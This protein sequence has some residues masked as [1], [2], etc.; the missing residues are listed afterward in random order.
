MAIQSYFYDSVNNDRPYSA[1]DFARAFGMILTNGVIADNNGSLGFNL[2]STGS[3]IEVREGR[4]TIQGYFVEV[5]GT[6]VVTVPSGSYSGQLVLRVDI[7]GER[8]ASLVVKTDR[9][10]TQDASMFELPLYNLVVSGGS[11]TSTINLRVQ[12]GA[13]AKT[14]SN[15]VTWESST[16]GVRQIT[17]L[18]NG[19][20]KPIVV[21]F[22]AN[23]PAASPSEH[24]VWIQ[25]ENF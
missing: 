25:I 8:R 24:R 18:Y 6:E 17:G 20:G 14:A 1:S 23:R 11:V 10:P 12:G 19:N 15:V 9:S 3:T 21:Y 13:I 5:T 16:T 7:A 2:G 22:T 4:A